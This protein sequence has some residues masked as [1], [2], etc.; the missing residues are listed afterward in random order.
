VTNRFPARLAAWLDAVR[1][2]VVGVGLGMVALQLAFRAAA[3]FN[4]WFYADDFEFLAEATRAPLT[5][6][7][8][9]AP[10]DSQFMPAGNLA[11]W[12]VAHS[13]AFNWPLA[14]AMVLVLQA[15]AS[16]ACLVMLVSLFGPRWETLVC[17]ALYL[18]STMTLTA[19]MWWAA[20]I[21]NV[22]CQLTFFVCV[23][24]HVQYLRTRRLRY[25]I[26]A[27]VVLAL[28]LCFYVKV[29]LVVLP[30]AAL[31]LVYFT[32]PGTTWRSRFSRLVAGFWP[33]IV[34]YAVVVG[35]YAVYYVRSVPNPVASE[36]P[37]AW[38]DLLDAMVRVSLAT[39]SVGGPWTWSLDN[40]PLGQVA[41]PAWAV[42]LVWMGLASA[43]TYAL[44]LR[45]GD[46][47][48]LLV[49]VP[50]LAVS[51]FLVAKGRATLL[52]GF[53]G[54][55]LRYLADSAPVLT[56]AVALFL[57]RL[58]GPVGEPAT[59]ARPDLALSRRVTWVVG[60]AVV[61]L[62]AGSIVSNVRYARYWADSFPAKAYTK[63]VIFE[64][65]QRPLVVVDEPVPELVMSATSYPSN[66]P[67]R[68]FKPLGPQR[69]RAVTSGTD[70]QM[71]NSLGQPFA[72]VVGSGA[73]SAPGP[74][75]DCG[76]VVK[77]RPVD[78]AMSGDPGFFWW[79]Q[80]SYLSASD[81][82]VEVSLGGADHILPLESGPHTLLLQGEGSIDDLSVR[83]V[84][85]SGVCVDSV[86]IGPVTPLEPLE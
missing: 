76:Y 7:Y 75:E 34:A 53:A 16:T 62:A 33:G 54:L 84:T 52:G 11:A 9:L 57:M 48:A 30:L 10:H 15:A 44:L 4:G 42:T 39:S 23:T 43:A 46:W 18:F 37:V 63:T 35:A 2:P 8:L 50:Y 19:Y 27:A 85:G 80:M 49:F 20:A 36:A 47:R 83:V 40:P 13:G 82:T 12:L 31:T 29:A 14:A 26:G 5:L 17:L 66:L 32:A 81:G 22:P 55:E 51:Y 60:A 6:D 56:L 78:I 45:R 68:M 64:S 73:A 41:T 79:L 71:L 25:G 72:A 61:A 69:F 24:L 74:N 3:V 86:T 70:L 58:R 21:N 65:G 67:S 38:G 59:G 77:G 28:G 1:H